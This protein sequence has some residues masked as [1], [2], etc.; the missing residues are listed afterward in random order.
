MKENDDAKNKIR[1]N[2]TYDVEDS[3]DKQV[4]AI[5]ESMESFKKT[6]TDRSEEVKPI[7]EKIKELK[8][9]ML[10]LES[11]LSKAKRDQATA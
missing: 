7:L 6:I 3:G 10:T 9:E 4:A 1:N 11:K 5:R 2:L 8:D